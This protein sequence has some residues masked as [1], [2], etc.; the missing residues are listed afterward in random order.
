M[1]IRKMLIFFPLPLITALV[2]M[3]AI[4]RNRPVHAFMIEKKYICCHQQKQ[5][6]NRRALSST[7]TKMVL[8]EQF[9]LFK[10]ND[11]WGNIAAICVTAS[12]SHGIGKATAVGRLLG[13]PVTAMAIA[14]LLGSIGVLPSC[15]AI[16]FLFQSF[17]K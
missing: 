6:Q 2:P 7:I 13:P 12:I 5:P 10:Q 9:P 15:T 1:N 3:R 16:L 8:K 11:S 17:C 14:F 4:A